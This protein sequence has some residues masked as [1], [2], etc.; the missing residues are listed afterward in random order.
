MDAESEIKGKERFSFGSNWLN[1]LKSLN[2]ERIAEAEKS[3]L[4]MLGE[5]T[6]RGRT[7]LDVGSG[8][9]LFSLAARRMGAKVRSFDYDPQSVKCTEELKKRYSEDDPDWEISGGNALDFEWLSSLGEWDIVYSWGVLHHTGDMWAAL[10]NVAK[11]VKPGGALFI[12]IYNDQG[13][14]SR[15]WHSMKKRYNKGSRFTKIFLVCSYG[16]V[17]SVI[18]IVRD[19]FTRFDPFYHWK[20][21]KRHRGMSAWHDLIDWV[22]GYPFEVAKP[23]AIFDFYHSRGFNLERLYTCGGRLSCN[24]FVFKK[25]SDAKKS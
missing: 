17:A 3:L 16:T 9:G 24:Q 22:G 2:D 1:F 8:S 25:T 4:G 13:W 14:I 18:Y 10:A 15:I 20:E 19:L 21:Y 23:E 11:L 6:L 12:S 5:E 7:F